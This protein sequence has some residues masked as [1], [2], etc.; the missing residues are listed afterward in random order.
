[1]SD[2][3]LSTVSTEDLLKAL[4]ERLVD[5]DL[6][7][8]EHLNRWQAPEQIEV[9]HAVLKLLAKPRLSNNGGWPDVPPERVHELAYVVG[10]L[11][12]STMEPDP[13]GSHVIR[14]HYENRKDGYLAAQPLLVPHKLLTMEDIKIAQRAISMLGNSIDQISNAITTAFGYHIEDIELTDLGHRELAMREEHSEE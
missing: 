2:I 12:Q 13:D 11:R 7:K 4:T 10:L 5:V 3:D 8:L 14:V 1:M 6:K 9:V